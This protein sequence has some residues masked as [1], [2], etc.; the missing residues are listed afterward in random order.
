[1]AWVVLV[2]VLG[3]VVGLL[4]VNFGYRR[5]VLATLAVLLVIVGAA[6]LYTQ[7]QDSAKEGRIAVAEVRF[8]EFTMQPAYGDSYKLIARVHNMS[9]DHTLHYFGLT[10]TAAD[11]TGQQ[12]QRQCLV[13]GEQSKEIRVEIPPQQARDITSQFAFGRMRTRGELQWDHRITYTGGR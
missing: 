11:C 7:L 3:I 10:V 1:M 12:D 6:L 2:V 13:V 9:S 8:E 4:I 5:S